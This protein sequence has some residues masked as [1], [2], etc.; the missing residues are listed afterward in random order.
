MFQGTT[1]SN[2]IFNSAFAVFILREAIWVKF[3]SGVIF[4]DQSQ[5]FAT[6]S[7]QWDCFICMDNRLRQMA[8]FLLA[9]VGKG[10]LSSILKDF[11]I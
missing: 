3:D 5:F 2:G 8:F 9:K 6:Y 4:L 1:A 10:R 7:N 11:E